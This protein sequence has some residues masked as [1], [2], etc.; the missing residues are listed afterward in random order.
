MAFRM[1]RLSYILN[2]VRL[3]GELKFISD[4]WKLLETVPV[5][6]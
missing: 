6:S 1:E 5:A 3:R 4:H 2:I